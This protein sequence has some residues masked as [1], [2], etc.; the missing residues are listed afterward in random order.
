MRNPLWPLPPSL[1]TMAVQSRKIQLCNN[2][3]GIYFHHK[4][5]REHSTAQH[6]TA[7]IIDL[8]SEERNEK[9]YLILE[10]E[11][12]YAS[13]VR[14]LLKAPRPFFFYPSTSPPWCNHPFIHPITPTTPGHCGTGFPRI[15]GYFRGVF[16]IGRYC[17]SDEE[18]PP[19]Q[20][21]YIQS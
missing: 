13:P 10:F 15:P 8:S 4:S 12:F 16:D 1:L 14:Y 2:K 17:V 5:Q 9:M 18:E 3:E 7:Q 6:S 21:L 11:D 19:F 20:I